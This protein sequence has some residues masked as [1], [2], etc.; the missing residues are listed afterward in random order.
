MERYGSYST[1]VQT[2]IFI[3]SENN[4]ERFRVAD[5]AGDMTLGMHVMNRYRKHRSYRNA[6]HK[7]LHF[8]LATLSA[9]WILCT[10][11]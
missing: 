3:G 4:D 5:G 6:I 11:K 7:S 2:D 10:T 9:D 8:P 1:Y